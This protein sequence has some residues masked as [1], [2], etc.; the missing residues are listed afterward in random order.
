MKNLQKGSV[1]VWI[2]IIA[3]IIIVVGVIYFSLKSSDSEN[4]QTSSEQQNTT[5]I[6]F[7]KGEKIGDFTVSAVS[8]HQGS[9]MNGNAVL[10]GYTVSFTGMTTLSGTFT[11]SSLFGTNEDDPN[12]VA[13]F[14]V[15][16]ADLNKIPHDRNNPNQGPLDLFYFTN[17]PKIDSLK[18]IVYGQK[19]TITISN[20]Q[21]YAI[22]SEGGNSATF[23]NLVK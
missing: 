10:A 20:F 12:T 23:V 1:T 13:A 11:K 22:E 2:V 5:S 14:K 15:D 7:T 9:D 21:L 17:R 3:L 18:G 19:H 16:P 8:P 6:P 4:A